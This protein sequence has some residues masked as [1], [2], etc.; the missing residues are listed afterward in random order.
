M[1][2]EGK[3]VD[4]MTTR[5]AFTAAAV[6]ATIVRLGELDNDDDDDFSETQSECDGYPVCFYHVITSGTFFFISDLLIVDV[7][8]SNV[9]C[10][11]SGD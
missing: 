3:K 2:E 8:C 6:E 7:F 9:K 10:V 4:S 11:C 1:E 5:H